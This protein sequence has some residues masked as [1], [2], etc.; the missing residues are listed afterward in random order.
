M[1]QFGNKIILKS[2]C[3]FTL[4][5]V[6]LIN[7]YSVK[8]APSVSTGLGLSTDVQPSL[9]MDVSLDNYD[10]GHITAGTPNW[11]SNES[12]IY[13]T[14]NSSNGYTI[15]I[16]DLVPG[17]NS[18]LLHSDNTTRIPD[19]SANITNPQPWS[20][21]V[22]K[23][24][25]FSIFKADTNKETR[26]GTGTSYNSADNNYAGIEESN[27]AIHSSPGFKTTTDNTWITFVLD[28]EAGQKTGP[29]SGSITLSVTANLE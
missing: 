17:S 6:I 14:T 4:L 11:G 19:F 27:V 2:A 9:L 16:K 26:W 12:I 18:A 15:D 21:G 29:Y 13:I 1:A 25:G 28:V 3:V 8:A 24:V 20:Y 10:F 5:I 7:S 23:G 22:S